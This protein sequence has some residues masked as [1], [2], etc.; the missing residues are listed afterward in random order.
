MRLKELREKCGLSQ[1]KLA[2]ISG[3]SQSFI[4][5]L[6]AGKKQPTITTLRKLSSA[7]GVTVSEL[8]GESRG[9]SKPKASGE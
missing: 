6:E 3:V 5:D 9:D 4:N 7:L 1:L 8:I 2:E